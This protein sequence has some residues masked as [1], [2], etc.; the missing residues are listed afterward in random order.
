MSW[1]DRMTKDGLVGI[2]PVEP[3]MAGLNQ[4]VAIESP[5][6]AAAA[7]NGMMDRAGRD[8]MAAG[9]ALAR[10]PGHGGRGDHLVV[11][12]PWGDHAATPGVLVLC[13]LDTVHPVGS[14]KLNPIRR[15]GNRAYGPGIQD[16]KAG[17][18]MALVALRRLVDAGRTTPLP[19]TLLYTSDEET[20]STTSRALIE[21]HAS[22][23]RYALVL[24]PARPG[25]KVVTARK[26]V[27]RFEIAVIGR[28]SHAGNAHR[29]GRSAIRELAAQILAVEGMTDYRRGI[30]VNVGR[31]SGGTADNVVPEHAWASVDLRVPNEADADEMIARIKA[32]KPVYPDTA[33]TVTGQLNRVPYR[34][35]DR[36]DIGD[37]FNH[38]AALA[39]DI[40]FTLED[41]PD[42]E[43]A[44]GSDV[45]FCVPYVPALDGLGPLGA[46]LHTNNEYIEVDSIQPRG[47]LLMHLLQTLR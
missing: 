8:I 34:R 37:L 42:G 29:D 28:P 21:D 12:S 15:E 19:V 4:W 11:R 35:T 45:Q 27:A 39:R 33:V 2:G 22:R 7:V 43:G 32:L 14:L 5:T 36:A 44:G 47:D 6:S 18:Y 31:I 20:G 16:M 40:G 26:G 9:L 38:A 23:S 46:G 3:F 1:G 10:V 30:T 17:A 13:H 41:L 25:G 24:E